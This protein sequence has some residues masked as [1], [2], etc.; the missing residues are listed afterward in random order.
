MV[1][2]PAQVPVTPPPDR[3]APERISRAL[4]WAV[5]LGMA[6]GALL[7][8]TVPGLYGDQA[9]L[10]SMMRGFDLVTLAGAVPM[11]LLSLAGP[12]AP[13]PRA[14]LVQIGGLVYALYT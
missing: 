3:T 13:S 7:G 1:M 8:L 10:A 12:L 6:L 5:T 11:L 2:S 9:A 14:G 4:T